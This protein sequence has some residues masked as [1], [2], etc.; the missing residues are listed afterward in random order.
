MLPGVVIAGIY[1]HFSDP[2]VP[3]TEADEYVV[4]VNTGEAP[5]DLR[6]WSLTNRKQDQV[7][8]YRYMFPRFLSNGDPWELEPGGMILLYTGR[9]TNGSTA[10]AGEARQY[11]LYQHRNTP[12]WQDPGDLACLHDRAGKLVHTCEQPAYRRAL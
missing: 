11:H 9:G 1:S 7:H 10:T 5:V 6:G 2:G 12:V 8:H 3:P 4:L